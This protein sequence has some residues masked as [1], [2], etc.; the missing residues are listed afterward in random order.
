MRFLQLLGLFSAINVAFGSKSEQIIMG[1]PEEETFARPQGNLPTLADLLTVE[2]RGSIFYTYARQTEISESWSQPNSKPI[3]IFMPTN[4]AVMALARKPNQDPEDKVMSESGFD[5]ASKA[6]VERWVGAHII[7]SGNVDFSAQKPYDT[8][9]PEVTIQFKHITGAYYPPGSPRI[10]T[11]AD[12]FASVKGQA[13]TENIAAE[14]KWKQYAL[15][16]DVRLIE[17]REASNG[18]IYLIE[19]TV[20]V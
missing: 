8:L 17:R 2:T 18:V 14:P 6:N 3:T 9:T 20:S 5:E 15:N 12:H 13:K 19:G 11:D 16:G 1:T 10:D 7:P 4:K